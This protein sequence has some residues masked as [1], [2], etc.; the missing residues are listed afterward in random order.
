VAKQLLDTGIVAYSE[1]SFDDSPHEY[2]KEWDDWVLPGQGKALADC[3]Q[4]GHRGCIHDHIVQR[5]R[6]SC[7]R[8][9][10][11]TCYEGWAS[12]EANI[13]V[14]RL[15][16]YGGRW[17]HPNHFSINPAPNLWL[18]EPNK[19][20]SLMYKEAKKRGIEGGS[21]IIHAKRKNKAG[22]WYISPH[23]HVIGFGWLNNDYQVGWV[24]K[25]HG[26]RRT[27]KEV[28]T[29]IR[30]QLSHA[31]VHLSKHTVRWFGSC[32]HL[33]I[34]FVKYKPP[35]HLCPVC[36]MELKPLIWIGQG[37]TPPPLESYVWHDGD[38][39][40]A[41]ANCFQKIRD[42]IEGYQYRLPPLDYRFCLTKPS[43]VVSKPLVEYT[44]EA[45]RKANP[46]MPDWMINLF[47]EG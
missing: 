19:L 32:F 42:R 45:L 41:E 18:L 7:N 4:F 2:N 26:V 38:W 43:N 37:D 23:A 6:R 11:P 1:N 25:N 33:P 46:L 5:Y 47:L 40:Y 12:L 29:T 36:G 3:G 30:Y 9:S 22:E 39:Q 44:Y 13:V 8:P 16:Q 27:E 34:D 35:K 28:Y 10:C 31:G 15:A 14:N 20:V 24:V 17:H 21:L